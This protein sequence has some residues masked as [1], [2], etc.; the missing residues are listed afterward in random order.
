MC[1]RSAT[2]GPTAR[3][4]ERKAAEAKKTLIVHRHL[5]E[6]AFDVLVGGDPQTHD[7]MVAEEIIKAAHK[8]DIVV[9]AQASMARIVPLLGNRVSV[10]VLSSPLSGVKEL[11]RVVG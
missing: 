9:L 3:L 1:A 6:G 7:D 11:K 8:S 5:A 10:P 4:V 2:L